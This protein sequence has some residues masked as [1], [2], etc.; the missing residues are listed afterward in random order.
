[1]ESW[2]KIIDGNK[3]INITDFHN[4]MFLDAR[5]ESP[6]SNDS[7][8]TINGVDGILPGA[9]SF[10]PFSLVLRFGFDGID[11]K[12][13][14]LFEHQFRPVFN[15][16][17]PYY[18]ITSQLPGVKYAINSANIAPTVKDGMSLEME[19][20]LNVYKGYSESVN[21][22]NDEFLFESNWMFENGLPLNIDPVY[23]HTTNQFTIWNGSTDMIDP[24]FKHELKILLNLNADGGFELVNYTTGD[25]FRYNKSISKDI[26]FVLDGVYAYRDGNRVG[27][28]TNRGVITLAE[29]KNELKIKGDVSDITSE[30]KFPF[31]YR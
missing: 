18:I 23:K 21:W 14:Y 10:A 26:D 6:N 19:V 25:S 17:N 27:I 20:T 11:V 7:S 24:R 1:M 12:D 3:E 4:F 13:L 31:I 8:I 29:G 15:R 22:T 9:T 28:D 5:T 30:F 2:V 16:R